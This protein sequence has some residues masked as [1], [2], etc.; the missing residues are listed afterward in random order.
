MKELPQKRPVK[1]LYEPPCLEK[2]LLISEEA[3]YACKFSGV[4]PG[5]APHGS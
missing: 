4:C 5:N 3:V 2:I 1:R